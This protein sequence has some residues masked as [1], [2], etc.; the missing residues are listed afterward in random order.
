MIS[1]FRWFSS[2][3]VLF[4]LGATASHSQFLETFDGEPKSE[5][6]TFTGD[7]EAVSSLEWHDG[8]ARFVVDATNDKHNIWWAI[9]RTLSADISDYEELAKPGYE[10]KMEARVRSSHAPRRLNMQLRTQ[11]T[12]DNYAHLMEFDIPHSDKWHTISMTTRQFDVKPGDQINAHIALMDWGPLVYTLDVDYVRVDIVNVSDTTPDKGEQVPYPPPVPQPE[13]FAYSVPALE[14]GMIDAEYPEVN[15]RSWADGGTPILSVDNSKIILLR[16][17]LNRYR[18][19]TAE[20]YGMLELVPYSFSYTEETALPEL[21]RI[22]LVEILSGDESWIREEVTYHSFTMNEPIE[23]VLNTQMII[24]IDIPLQEDTPRYI[25]I[26]RP[27]IQRML[28]GRT[29][30]I[31]LYPLGPLHASFYPGSSMGNPFRPRLYFNLSE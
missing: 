13:E 18:N 23:Q 1:L 11:R 7:G 22:R 6:V 3:M 4:L 28:N 12:T 29:K 10:L 16:W 27:V 30:G 26:P 24:D 19:R 8:F 31:A 21:N 20:G 14:T 15:F 25:H 9:M 2:L 5:W 17:N